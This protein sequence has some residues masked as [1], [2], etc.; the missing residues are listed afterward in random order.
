MGTDIIPHCLIAALLLFLFSACYSFSSNPD[1]LKSYPSAHRA[2]P[3]HFCHVCAPDLLPVHVV[4]ASLV[5]VTLVYAFG[6]YTHASIQEC[7]HVHAYEQKST[8]LPGCLTLTEHELYQAPETMIISTSSEVFVMLISVPE[9]KL[10][11]IPKLQTA[12]L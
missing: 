4:D 12:P 10:E 9:L 8:R 5:G 11:T 3:S 2:I 7:T 1:P 6:I